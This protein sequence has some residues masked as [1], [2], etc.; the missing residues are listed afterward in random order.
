MPGHKDPEGE[1]RRDE[2][3]N[4]FVYIPTKETPKPKVKKSYKPK[5]KDKESFDLNDDGKVDAED[6][7][8]A[9]EK[10]ERK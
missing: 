5:K 6:V 10:D 7:K 3:G 8:I 1:I 4:L 2:K 9:L